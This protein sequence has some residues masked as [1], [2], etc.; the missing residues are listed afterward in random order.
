MKNPLL[1]ALILFSFLISCQKND[2]L[3]EEEHRMEIEAWHA[4]KMA[5]LKSESGW[6]NLIGLYW[7]EEGENSFGSGESMAFKFENEEFPTELGVFF[8]EEGKVYF[9]P[10]VVGVESEGTAV[11][12]KT[13]IFDFENK[14]TKPLSYESLHWL[15]IKRADAYGVRLRDYEA[16]AVRN[17]EGVEQYPVDLNW[18]I[19][20]MFIP[21]ESSKTIP[22][23]NVIGQTT[24]N[25]TPGYLEFQIDGKTY[26]LDALEGEDD[27]LFL[28]FADETSGG[29]TYGGG[30]YMY[31]KK[32][33]ASGKLIIDFNKAYNPPCVYT[34]H[35]TCPLPPRQ[36][37][38]DVA[39]TAGHKNYGDH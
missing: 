30:R 28:I 23:T 25:P 33:D 38:L 27:E 4:E 12:G 11:E 3:S 21:Y 19:E 16:G 37:I 5:S 32:A 36:N 26:K 20:A 18:R 14:I 13:L 1:I 29:E 2:I 34:P 6:L 39:I 10:K 17:F 22:I 31:V 8:L 24:P 9:E 7:L 35:A 15:I